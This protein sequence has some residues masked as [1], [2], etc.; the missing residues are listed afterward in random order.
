MKF[1]I[2]I[3]I[4]T[5]LVI[6]QSSCLTSLQ[7]IVTYENIV[8]EDRILGNWQYN[9]QTF[10]VEEMTKSELYNY[11][12]GSIKN[13]SLNFTTHPLT[14]KSRQ[15]S[16]LFSKAYVVS[17]TANKVAYYYYA[18]LTH[19]NNN[20]FMQL[21]PVVMDDSI[22]E[23]TSFAILSINYQPTFTFAK[24]EAG[25]NNIMLK[26]LN[27]DYIKEQIEKGNM[28]IKHEEDKL[29]ASYL[30]TPSTYEIK[31]FLQKYGHDERLYS[32]KNSV[33]LTRKD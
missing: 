17:F 9:N 8:K 30:L 3:V 19:I 1:L 27:G 4:V 5:I 6:T 32:P 13:K 14:G 15:D 18:A 2:T 10:R 21:Y 33:T 11:I 16:I 23:N 24:V 22:N 12:T 25:S 31:Q 29:F 7:P 28:R 26:F 20:L